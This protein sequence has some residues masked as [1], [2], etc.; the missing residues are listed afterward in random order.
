VD[1]GGYRPAATGGGPVDAAG[2]RRFNAAVA[3]PTIRAGS[4]MPAGG[5]CKQI[6]DRLDAEEQ[7]AVVLARCAVGRSRKGGERRRS[8]MASTAQATFTWFR[9][10]F[11]AV[12]RAR[13][14]VRISHSASRV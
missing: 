4:D 13:S 7:V 8:D 6:A 10:A 9:P 12:Y 2:V 14:A 1:K 3:R 11:L 5:S